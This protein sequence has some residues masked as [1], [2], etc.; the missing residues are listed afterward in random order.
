LTDILLLGDRCNELLTLTL[1]VHH[2]FAGGTG[3]E[4]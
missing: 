2:S 4:L 3:T 1:C